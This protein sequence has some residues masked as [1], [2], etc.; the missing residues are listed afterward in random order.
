M[1]AKPSRSP[2]PMTAVALILVG[3]LAGAFAGATVDGAT[4]D[5]ATVDGAMVD[6]DADAEAPG[7]VAGVG[8]GGVIASLSVSIGVTVFTRPLFARAA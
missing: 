8:C 2:S 7:G 3:T 6:A 1:N 4:V 5:G